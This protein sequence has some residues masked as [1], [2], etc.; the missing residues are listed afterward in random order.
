MNMIAV[1][2]AVLAAILGAGAW[3]GL[4][5]ATDYEIGYAAWGIG[6]LVGWAGAKFGG[7]G[8]GMALLCAVLALASI[9]CGKML[10]VEHFVSK[11]LDAQ[12]GTLTEQDYE[13]EKGQAAEFASLTSEAQYPEFM[14][15]HELTEAK[16]PASIPAEE[17]EAFKEFSVPALTELNSN[18][19]TFEQWKA[20][21]KQEQ[22]KVSGSLL[23][24][25]ILVVSSLGLIDI[26]FA[27]LGLGSAYG[28][29]MRAGQE[30]AAA[31]PAEPTPP[32]V[33]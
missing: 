15:K 30:Q 5:V 21:I 27:V 9:F 3:A 22:D 2:M 11:E 31:V 13:N 6:V 14:V 18:P 16:D 23:F 4:V 26:V 8:R 1:L 29:V 33:Q 25:A 19:P 12:F 7:R 24:M 20:N 32:P 10:A 28:F 17:V